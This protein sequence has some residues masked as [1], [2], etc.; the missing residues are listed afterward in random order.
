MTRRQ[1]GSAKPGWGR[2]KERKT[3]GKKKERDDYI[4]ETYEIG[5]IVIN[6]SGTRTIRYVSLSLSVELKKGQSLDEL[7]RREPKIRDRINLRLRKKFLDEFLFSFNG[8]NLRNELQEI[9]EEV[10]PP[11]LINT[12]YITEYIIN[13]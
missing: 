5:G 10:T 9:I 4:G 2:G 1:A 11:G 3:E 8:E 12:I 7:K 13:W 6:P